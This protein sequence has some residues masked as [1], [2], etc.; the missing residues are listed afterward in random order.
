MQQ[1]VNQILTEY[2]RIKH[3]QFIEIQYYAA[4]FVDKVQNKMYNEISKT[5]VSRKEG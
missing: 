4:Q 5:F 3:S 1:K 2:L